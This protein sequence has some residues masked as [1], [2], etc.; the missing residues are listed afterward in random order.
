[1]NEDHKGE[2]IPKNVEHLR[3][4][5]EDI[6]L[7]RDMGFSVDNGNEPAPEN[8]PSLTE[9]DGTSSNTNDVDKLPGQQKLQMQHVAIFLLEHWY[10]LHCKMIIISKKVYFG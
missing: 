1:M 7:R 3:G 5:T 8:V 9:D 4:S 6:C 2:Y 10:V